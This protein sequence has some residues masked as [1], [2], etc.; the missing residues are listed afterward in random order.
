MLYYDHG[1]FLDLTVNLIFETTHIRPDQRKMGTKV[2]TFD[3]FDVIT[4]TF[5]TSF[6]SFFIHLNR[7]HVIHS[8]NYDEIYQRACYFRFLL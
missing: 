5:N 2:M 3:N 4:I 7:H 6:I 1:D 8:R